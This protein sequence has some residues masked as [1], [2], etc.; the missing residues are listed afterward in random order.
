MQHGR[1]LQSIELGQRIAHLTGDGYMTAAMV[2][3]KKWLAVECAVMMV[4][5]VGPL[6]KAGVAA[7]LE[8]WLLRAPEASLHHLPPLL[9]DQDGTIGCVT[10]DK[11]VKGRVHE[12]IMAEETRNRRVP[13]SGSNSHNEEGLSFGLLLPRGLRASPL[14]MVRRLAPVKRSHL[15]T[16]NVCAMV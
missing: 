5:M 16:C 9:Q 8:L 15:T 2:V 11:R 10:M 4:M 6:Q 1:D 13:K 3:A 14:R 12:G 7:C